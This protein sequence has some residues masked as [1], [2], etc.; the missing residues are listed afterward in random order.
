MQIKGL[1]KINSLKCHI[2]NQQ[3]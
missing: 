1:N 2:N 3:E